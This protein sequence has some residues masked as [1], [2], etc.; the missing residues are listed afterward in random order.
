VCAAYWRFLKS[1]NADGMDLLNGMRVFTRVAESGS[2]SA[3]ARE[4][5]VTQPTVSK[6][7]AQLEAHFGAQLIARSTAGLKLTDPGNELYERCKSVV[8]Q[9]AGM[10]SSVGAAQ[11]SV[12]GRLR[13]SAPTAFGET[14][15]APMLLEL[16][17]RLPRLEVDL[18]LNDRWFDL[19]EDGID[20][21]LRFGPLPDS[22]LIA[23]KL[24]VSPQA[25]LASPEYLKTHGAPEH[26]R[27][28]ERHRCIVNSLVS[29]TG[30]WV[31]ADPDGEIIAHV[32][33][34]FRTNNLGAI[35]RAV[36]AGNGIAI[37]PVWLYYEDLHAGRIRLLLERFD[38]APLEINALYVANAFQPA[39]VKAFID[40]LEQEI[41]SAPVLARTLLPPAAPAVRPG[42]QAG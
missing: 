24:G 41:R 30:R 3:V 21:A 13:I 4:L 27:E 37:G 1:D 11:Q 40:A 18:I 2:F 8:E 26:P 12:S 25:C 28:L 9:V 29:P 5:G 23:R 14:Y 36:L 7:V 31:F 6:I 34:N 32:S 39:K 15:L 10:E 16:A 20:V 38:P 19:L 35:R 17:Q 22:R 42:R 33:G